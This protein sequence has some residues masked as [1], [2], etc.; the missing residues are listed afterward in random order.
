MDCDLHKQNFNHN[1]NINHLPLI[2]LYKVYKGVKSLKSVPKNLQCNILIGKNLFAEFFKGILKIFLTFKIDTRI[3]VR[4]QSGTV[5]LNIVVTFSSLLFQ[6]FSSPF[7]HH[8]IYL[9]KN[10]NVPL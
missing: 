1:N 2:R 10:T 7:M 8:H 9:E 6:H 4:F 5:H 3:I